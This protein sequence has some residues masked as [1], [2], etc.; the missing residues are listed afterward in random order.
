MKKLIWSIIILLV[1][2]NSFWVYKN[3]ELS[4]E[5]SYLEDEKNELE[6]KV[7]DLENEIE[8]LK[9]DYKETL[10]EH[11]DYLNS[12]SNYLNSQRENI[13]NYNENYN[14]DNSVNN[15]SNY[16]QPKNYI[17]QLNIAVPSYVQTMNFD[18][19]KVISPTIYNLHFLNSKTQS[20][21]EL[22]MSKNNYSLTTTRESFVSNGTKSCCYTIDK[23]T[24]SIA[25]I[26]TKSIDN[27]I[28]S[29][30]TDNSIDYTYEDGFRKYIYMLGNQKFALYIQSSSNKLIILLKNL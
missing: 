8:D 6:E 19:G 4:D 24:E 2:S 1:L 11:E 26:F 15:N 9:T 16:A 22:I 10:S 28:E 20:E 30:L 5:N 7:K 17:K 27:N 25:M 12:Q 21:F 18:Q 13:S 29:I 3:R 14:T 23:K